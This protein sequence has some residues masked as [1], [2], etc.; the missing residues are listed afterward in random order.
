[1]A[2]ITNAMAAAAIQPKWHEVGDFSVVC[3]Q[4]IASGAASDQ[5]YKLFTVASGAT[6]LDVFARFATAINVTNSYYHVGIASGG[7]TLISSQSV[8]YTYPSK[9]GPDV[10]LPY[11]CTADTDVY[12]TLG[13]AST[14]ISSF[15]VVARLCNAEAMD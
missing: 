14:A 1:M 13:V 9:G 2:T 12:M 7:K 4:A 8:G 11:E 5:D 3:T 6:I 10:T 15:I